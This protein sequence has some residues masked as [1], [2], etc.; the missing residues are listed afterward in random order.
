M[1][2]EFIEITSA[3][4]DKLLKITNEINEIMLSDFLES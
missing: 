3:G 4:L 2:Q 1:N